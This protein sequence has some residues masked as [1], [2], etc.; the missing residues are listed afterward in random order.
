MIEIELL[1]W[2]DFQIL[3]KKLDAILTAVTTTTAVTGSSK[4]RITVVRC[5]GGGKEVKRI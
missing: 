4:K 2:Q 5:T 3:D 1:T